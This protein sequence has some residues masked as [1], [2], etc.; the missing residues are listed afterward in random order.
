MSSYFSVYAN[1]KGVDICLDSVGT[2]PT[3]WFRQEFG[4]LT[5]DTETEI[6]D[7]M[8]RAWEHNLKV[9]IADQ[10]AQKQ[11]YVK[12]LQEEK[13]LL[14]SATTPAAADNI[15]IEIDR[16]EEMIGYYE[17]EETFSDIWCARRILKMVE[18]LRTVMA[19]NE[20]NSEENKVTFS[21]YAD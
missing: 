6:T 21:Y 14:C 11:E 17:D 1:K 15:R 13:T 9:F 19:E 5:Y 12:K 18:T 2:T 8:A 16:L 7:S 10:E 20:F 3:R 4:P